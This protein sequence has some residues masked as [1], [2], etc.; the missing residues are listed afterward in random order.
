V[1]LLSVDYGDGLSVFLRDWHSEHGYLRGIA[2]NELGVAD[3]DG[4]RDAEFI[5]R[6]DRITSM[7]EVG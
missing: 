7:K 5:V 6:E 2:C 1:R 4:C 3:R